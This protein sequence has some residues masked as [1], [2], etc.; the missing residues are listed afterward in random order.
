M[1]AGGLLLPHFALRM[2]DRVAGSL[3]CP[4]ITRGLRKSRT[5]GEGQRW[6]SRGNNRRHSLVCF[7]SQAAR[8]AA[9]LSLRSSLGALLTE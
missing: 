4:A 3:T 8:V 6:Q 7:P 1:C 2:A 5:G 9:L